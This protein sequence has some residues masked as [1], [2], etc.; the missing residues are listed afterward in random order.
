MQHLTTHLEVRPEKACHMAFSSAAF[1]FSHFL[2]R[3]AFLHVICP[4]PTVNPAL[5]VS[6]WDVCEL[7]G[8][9]LSQQDVFGC[10]ADPRYIP[11]L[12]PPSAWAM[13]C[14]LRR[15]QRVHN[16]YSRL[17]INDWFSLG[18]TSWSDSSH[19]YNNGYIGP[20][21]GVWGGWG[22]KC[23]FKYNGSSLEWK[24]CILSSCRQ[25]QRGQQHPG[26][27]ASFSSGVWMRGQ[28]S[29]YQHLP[30]PPE[31]TPVMV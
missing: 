27:L 15:V 7:P 17:E 2:L 20:R 6:G 3:S 12:H 11:A 13:V 31:V 1:F 16:D 4:T 24:V 28:I 21:Q 10:H 25:Y 29:M 26:E 14:C 9:G 18:T 19:S 22:K 23:T 30:Q 5:L 8:D